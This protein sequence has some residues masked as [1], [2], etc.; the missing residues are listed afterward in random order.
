MRQIKVEV[1]FYKIEK[2]N[3]T[4]TFTFII[5]SSGHCMMIFNIRLIEP[6]PDFN[7]YL[8]LHHI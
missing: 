7:K 3:K 1:L 4:S 2:S 8:H 6:S 5:S